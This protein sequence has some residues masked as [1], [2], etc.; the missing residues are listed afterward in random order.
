MTIKQIADLCGVSRGTVDRVLNRRGKVKPET[1]KRVLH[2]I[3]K[4][5]YTKNIAGKALTLKKT[6][7][8]IGAVISSEG[9]PFFD[10]VIKG[11]RKAENELKDYG[12]SL[13]LKT[14]RG[15]DVH[16]Q[17]ELIGEL[18]GAGISALVIQP[19]NDTRI[20][21]KLNELG[22]GGVP[23]I[24]VNTD[25][26]NSC[27]SCYVGSD[28]TAGGV[29]AAG[30]MRIVTGGKAKLGIVT[31]VSMLLGHDQRRE[32]FERH[33]KA[34]CPDITIVDSA[35]AMDDTEHSYRMTL[36]MLNR[37]PQIDAI[38]IVAAGAEG[39]CRAVMEKK[40]EDAIR[41]VAFDTV[42]ATVSMMRSGLVR[43]VI[44]QQPLRQGHD[45]LIAAFDILL[46]GVP[47]QGNRII[48][49]HQIKILENL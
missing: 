32:G 29:T 42:P 12:V 9:N 30:V 16:R 22:S 35:S 21:E 23:T 6:T 1:E 47:K 3:R 8:V 44:C 14:M 39:V 4:L 43:A 41:V 11:F 31:G 38:F 7:P 20:A 19:I 13:E 25:I 45:S 40:R 46:S 10:D 48:M 18:E 2:A 36:E 15:Y 24:T 37:N 28:Y 27:R 49:E 34:V 5:G 33:I 26:E 17:L